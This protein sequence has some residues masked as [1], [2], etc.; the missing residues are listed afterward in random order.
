MHTGVA[1]VPETY[2]C[3]DGWPGRIIFH[4]RS[5]THWASEWPSI[6]ASDVTVLLHQKKTGIEGFGVGVGDTHYT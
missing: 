4:S 2:S 6:P 5:S 3:G 1:L